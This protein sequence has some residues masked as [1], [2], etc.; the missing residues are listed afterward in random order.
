MVHK[1]FMDRIVAALGDGDVDLL[2]LDGSINLAVCL[3]V[4]LQRV[5]L[6]RRDGGRLHR[7]SSR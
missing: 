3:P 4:A 2:Q 6:L 1:V 5:M 7:S